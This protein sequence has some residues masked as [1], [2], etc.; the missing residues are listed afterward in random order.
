MNDSAII[1]VENLHKWFGLLHVLKGVSFAVQPSEVLVLIGRS[2]SG[3]STL[4]RCLNFMEQPSAG[5]ITVAGQTVVTGPGIR[6]GRQ[7]ILALRLS[8][9]M[10]FQEF[11]LFPHM[12][13]LG[14][15]IEGLIT[16]KKMS[17]EQ[18]SRLAKST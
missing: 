5:S 2:G 11:N 3:K 6:P 16:V 14:N 9:G 8:M 10:V 7:Q 15:V 4:L 13:A 17:R 12:T 1:Q 18:A